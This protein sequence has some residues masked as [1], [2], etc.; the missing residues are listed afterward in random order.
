[1]K[2]DDVDIKNM[3]IEGL[4]GLGIALDD[5]IIDR[6][7]AYFILLLNKNKSMNL[8]SS[9]Q[10]VK[11]Q[12]AVHL[13][14][15]LSFLIMKEKIRRAN[16]EA[17]DFGSGG[18]LPGIPLSLA[19]PDW[20]YTLVE[21]TGKKAAFLSSVVKELGLDN[22]AVI[23]KFL[24][25]EVNPEKKSYELVTARAVSD[26]ATLAAIAGP[27]LKIGGFFV[28]FKGPQGIVELADAGTNLKKMKL[29]LVDRQDLILP[30]V[31]ARRCLF[32]FKKV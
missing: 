6:I 2:I 23:N 22:V 26:L 12:T 18:G 27:R 9:K 19:C 10:D 17:M 4:S 1:M 20:N 5:F 13:I 32:L 3:L 14:D 7:I 21:A 29:V 16:I 8:I 30:F 25:P 28:A 11:T 24:N 31:D 15:S